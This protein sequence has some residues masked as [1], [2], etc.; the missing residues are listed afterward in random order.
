MKT[1]EVNNEPANEKYGIGR[2]QRG[3]TGL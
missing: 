2:L 3:C 1:T